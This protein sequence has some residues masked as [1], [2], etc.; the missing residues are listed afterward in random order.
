MGFVPATFLLPA[1]IYGSMKFSEFIA[2]QIE[3][4]FDELHYDVATFKCPECDEIGN[5]KKHLESDKICMNANCS[6]GDGAL[7]SKL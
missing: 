6:A 4:V 2:S 5:H 3:D 7:K 1:A